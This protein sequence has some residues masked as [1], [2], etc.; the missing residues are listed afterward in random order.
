MLYQKREREVGLRIG[1]IVYNLYYKGRPY[2]DFE[3]DLALSS[4]N[5]VDLGD[6]NHSVAFAR[7]FLPYVSN[8]VEFV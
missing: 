6:V 2:S 3:G 1:R 5:G 7:K 8:S 4:M